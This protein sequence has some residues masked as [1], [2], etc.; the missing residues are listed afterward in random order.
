MK[1]LVGA[2]ETE[3]NA[4]IPVMNHISDF[5]WTFGDALL[6]DIQ[7]GNVF[8]EEG[9][10]MIPAVAVSSGPSG[11]IER[12]AFDY[13][14]GQFLKAVRKHMYEMD[15]IFLIF[16]GG[17]EV[18]GLGSG[19][20]HIAREIRKLTGPCVPVAIACDP[21]GNLCREYAEESA[22]IIRSYRHSPHTDADETCERVARMLCKLLKK[23]R[24][25]HPVYRRLPMLFE[26][27]QSV[28]E[29][30]PVASINRFMDDLEKDPRIMSCS[31]HVG[32]T[33]HDTPVAGCGIVVIPETEKDQDYAETI[34][35]RL[36]D[37]VWERR[38][39]FHFTGLAL[40]PDAA[41]DAALKQNRGPCVITDSGDNI[42]SGTCGW[43]TYILRQVL[44]VGKLKKTVLFASICDPHTCRFLY[45]K[46]VGEHVTISLGVGYDDLSQPVKM[47]VIVKGKGKSMRPVGISEITGRSVTVSV[48]DTPVDIIV[49]ED[50]AG[51]YMQEQFRRAGVNW[52]DY[53]ITVVKLGYIFPE[54]KEKAAFYV[55]SLT[56]GATWQEIWKLPYKR[57]LRPMFPIDDI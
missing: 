27:E 15:G 31:W 44:S 52:T 51:F 28:S 11:V 39:E 32:Y 26:G 55:M 17:S 13:I 1:V 12:D 25:I 40:E 21:H 23:R 5:R 19:D 38:R 54:L 3:S 41:L 47:D 18:E 33:R 43:N 53:D 48:L 2:F 42:T 49:T 14:E 29:D 9:I 16:H 7:G 6:E 22:T 35:D 45:E 4:Y 57:I 10:E 34:A 20:H 36:A 8:R 24:N 37:F 50:R 46:R 30:E 56:Q